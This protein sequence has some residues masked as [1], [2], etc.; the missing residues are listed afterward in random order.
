M[1]NLE[2]FNQLYD[3][4]KEVINQPKNAIIKRLRRIVTKYDALLSYYENKAHECGLKEDLDECF[5]FNAQAEALKGILNEVRA[6]VTLE[7]ILNDKFFSSK[8]DEE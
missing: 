8:K 7:D 2:L 4:S 1:T 5:K 3:L 6:I